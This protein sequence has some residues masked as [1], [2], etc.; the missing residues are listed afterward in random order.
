MQTEKPKKLYPILFVL[1]FVYVPIVLYFFTTNVIA[2]ILGVLLIFFF[3]RTGI[4]NR[5][6]YQ[7]YKE[8]QPV[9]NDTELKF[10][11]LTKTVQR[12][13]F[14]RVTIKGTPLT[15]YFI[16]VEYNE[17]LSDA[18]GLKP[19]TSNKKGFATWSWKIGGRTSIG[20]AHIYVTDGP[21]TIHTTYSVT[22]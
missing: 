4:K 1:A 7:E 11:S 17:K 9:V 8:N 10:V 6:A 21:Q 16:R 5:L 22:K 12:N 13:S 15:Q 14:A 19:V 2:G 20:D 3:I 18:S